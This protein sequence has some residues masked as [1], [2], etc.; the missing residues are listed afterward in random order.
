V[1]ITDHGKQFDCD[2]F[3]TFCDNL[4]IQLRFASVAYPQANG[5]AKVSNRTILYGL[6]TRLEGAKGTWVNELP[7]ILWAYRT[8]SRVTTGETP[9]NLVYGMEALIP[10][11]I[12]AKSP[13]LMAYEEENGIKNFEAL[14]ENLDLIEE[15]RDHAAMR[16]AAYHRRIASY[17]NSRVRN[18]PMEE[19]DL[20]LRKFAVTGALRGD[21]K[22]RA[23]WEGPY[24]ILKMIGPNTCILQT[25]LGETLEKTWNLNYLKLYTNDIPD[26]VF[27]II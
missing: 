9:F 20:V 22:L 27:I 10:I 13:W 8:T 3:R 15:Q 24:C 5:Q 6:R 4:G 19:G 11:E 2:S 12:S 23:N 16:M 18:R 21:G 14:R 25:L 1:I 26:K 17:Y 7:L